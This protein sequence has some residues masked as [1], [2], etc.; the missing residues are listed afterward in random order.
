MMQLS[1][2]DSRVAPRRATSAWYTALTVV[3]VF[4]FAGVSYGHGLPDFTDLVERYSPA[5]VNI[6]TVNKTQRRGAVP[7]IEN[8]PKDSPFY[9]WYRRDFEGGREAES[10][11][12]GFIISAD[13]LVVTNAH[14]VREAE[15]IIVRLSDRREFEAQLI[16]SD[17]SSDIAV[18]KIKSSGLPVVELGTNYDLK[19]GE[20][21]LA[22]GSPFGFEYSV[23]AGIVSAKGRSLPRENYVPF[24][25]TDVAINP[26]NSGGPL[27]NLEG[28]VVGVNAQIYTQNGQ[29]NGLS[30]AIPIDVAMDVADQLRAKGKVSR[31]WLGVMIQDV[32]AELAESFGM[33]R[34]RGAL[35]A[36]VLDDSPAAEAGFRVG[37]IVLTFN[38]RGVRR[39]SDLPPIVGR[40]R[41]NTKTP[42]EILRNGES[43]VIDVVIAELPEDPAVR[44][45][46]APP[47]S[48]SV[49]KLGVTVSDLNAEQRDSLGV[50]EGGVYVTDIVPGAAQSAGVR[51]G[52][53]I[54]MLQN[55]PVRDRVHFEELVSKLPS[56]KSVRVLVHRDK[57][58]IFLAMKTPE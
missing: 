29:F 57:T 42:V 13:G 25:Q 56:Q 30:F 43:M 28:Q 22:I 16:G 47:K 54:V 24:I 46:T 2:V 52:D 51:Q 53:A 11:G 41:V 48:M 27:F 31:G 37:D 45:A 36:K 44:V 18:L 15:K 20:W 1:A 9:E 21:V 58:P 50:T 7:G 4:G 26:G 55:K 23:T 6:S 12:S 39:S 10:L 38:E 17:D 34:P 3:L 49:E 33:N 5:V 32:T 8:V 14:V 35:I 19:V 40:T